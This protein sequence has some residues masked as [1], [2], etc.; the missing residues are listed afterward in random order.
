MMFQTVIVDDDP[1]SQEM[2]IDLLKTNFQNYRNIRI[3][4]TVSEAVDVLTV[5]QPDLVFL[6]ME[7]PDGKGFDVLNRLPNINF[8]VIVTTMHDE[9]MLN[10]I[11]HSAL[12]YLMKPVNKSELAAALEKFERR[13][14]ELKK[15]HRQTTPQRLSKLALP[16][17]DGMVFLNIPEIIRLESEG[18][19]TK[20][21]TTQ[22]DQYLTSKSIGNYEDQLSGHSFFRVHHGHLISLNHIR[23][24]VR[25]E[26]GYVIMSDNSR[27]D[28]SRRKKD[29]FMKAIG[30]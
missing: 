15:D 26:G 3:C 18:A 13:V 22:G 10:A 12:D 19:Y 7:L 27:V 16:T 30:L 23:K 17:Q 25:G 20:F 24:Y 29:D 21:I 5:Q 9:Y 14:A 8:E 4:N 6:D 11:R 1:F 2:M 28:V